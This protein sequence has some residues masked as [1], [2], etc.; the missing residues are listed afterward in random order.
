M[1]VVY[2]TVC[3][4]LNCMFCM[5]VCVYVY[6]LSKDDLD[7]NECN[8]NNQNVFKNCCKKSPMR[9]QESAVE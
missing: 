9:N 1:H 7:E 4:I 3:S 2:C 8:K 6:V 5:L